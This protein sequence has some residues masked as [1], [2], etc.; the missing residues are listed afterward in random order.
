MSTSNLGASES[1][2]DKEDFELACVATLAQVWDVG[3][4]LLRQP[5]LVR[6]VLS[7]RAATRDPVS[8]GLIGLVS[9]IVPSMHAFEMIRTA[10]EVFK[11]MLFLLKEAESNPDPI[12]RAYCLQSAYNFS[13]M[14]LPQLDPD[15]SWSA[16]YGE[17]GETLIAAFDSW[18]MEVVH[19][20]LKKQLS[21][22]WFLNSGCPVLPLAQRWGHMAM[23]YKN[24]DRAMLA[25]KRL[26]SD[27]L[28]PQDFLGTLIGSIMW[29]MVVWSCRLEPHR[30]EV[31][32]TTF[33]AAGFTWQQA[34]ETLDSYHGPVIRA[35][36]NRSTEGVYHTAE[37][38]IGLI[39]CSYVLVAKDPR[40]TE[41]EVMD[42]L[43]SVEDII[44][45][46][47]GGKEGCYMHSTHLLMNWFLSCAA[48]SAKFGRHQAAATYATAGLVPDV[49]KGG[50]ISVV[51]RVLLMTIQANA[52]AALDQKAE[53]IVAFEATIDI[54]HRA[55]LFLYEIFALRDLKMNLLDA[56][57]HAEH[58]SRRLGAALRLLIG[59]ADLVTPLLRGLDASELMALP[60]PEPGH[61]VAIGATTQLSARP[62][63]KDELSVA[64]ALRDELSCLKLKVLRK[65]ASDEGISEDE[66]EDAID[67]DE[68]K[69]ALIDLLV[70]RHASK[71]T[72]D[73]DVQ[74]ELRGMSV[75][76]LRARAKEA[77]IDQDE[78]DD[79]TDSDE[80]KAAIVALL[81]QHTSRPGV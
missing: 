57:G 10:K 5:E 25:T 44:E 71:S 50:T 35:R 13:Q 78:V 64:P 59:P 69:A 77:G 3:Q 33:A 18:D 45:L 42:D 63:L 73:S 36:G 24:L 14:D 53:A 22:D 39:K 70:E 29:P 67:S 74:S 17:T 52:F 2:P 32:A 75:R 37:I 56:M 60:E 68:P 7:T 61:T 26:I 11:L 27:G 54:A 31:V 43:P 16:L 8:V 66:V 47:C 21:G 34:T 20:F 80:P 55:E 23:V 46:G 81:M 79:A 28:D 30:C 58:G 9:N 49:A 62:A 19:P 65:R 6:R 1:D 76:D 72:Q 15:F 12:A 41:Q 40:A 38:V 51:T 4:D 48:V